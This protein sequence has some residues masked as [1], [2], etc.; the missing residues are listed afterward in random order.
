M[1]MGSLLINFTISIAGCWLLVMRRSWAMWRTSGAERIL[2]TSPS[3]PTARRRSKSTLSTC[4]TP[5][6]KRGRRS[7]WCI[8]SL[9]GQSVATST[10]VLRR[11][12]RIKQLQLRCNWIRQDSAGCWVCS[13]MSFHR[14]LTQ[15]SGHGVC[16]GLQVGRAS[17][18]RY[19]LQSR[20]KLRCSLE[21]GQT[22]WSLSVILW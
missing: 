17:R 20:R 16:R 12:C 14:L 6:Y 15:R 13:W 2:K 1:R 10:L 5:P 9:P 4:Y 22:Y 7:P 8:S 21:N 19:P 11:T 18:V 3:C